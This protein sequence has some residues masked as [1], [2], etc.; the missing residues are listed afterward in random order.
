VPSV[1]RS[2]ALQSDMTMPRRHV[3][4]KRIHRC[5]LA[6]LVASFVIYSVMSY[7]GVRSPDS[8]V[9]FRTGKSLATRGT[10][11]V[12]EE[13]EGWPGFGL[14]RAT[15][16]NRYSVFGPGES[17][18]IVPLI[19]FAQILNDA[20]WYEGVKGFIQ[21]SHYV[22]NGLHLY[23]EG[24]SPHELE[25][26]A[27]RFV[28]SFFNVLVS[29][30]AVVCFLLVLHELVRC[31]ATACLVTVL[32]AFGTP[33]FP[34]SG[35]F[36]SEPLA[37]LLC[38]VSL[39]CM[40]SSS[41][42]SRS[43]ATDPIRLAMA[44][45][46]LGA[47]ILTH[48]TAVLFVPF[49]LFYAMYKAFLGNR[50]LSH[51]CMAGLCFGG[52]VAAALAFL[53]YYNYV[54]FGHALETGR[55]VD[56]Q[57]EYGHFAIPWNGLYGLLFSPGKGLFLYAPAT[58]PALFLWP[59]FYRRRRFL[60]VTLLG[61]AL[62]RLVFIATRSDW[63]GGFCL[64]PRYMLM[65]VPFLLIPWGYF[66]RDLIA[67]NRTAY[68]WL[69]GVFVFACVSEQLYFCLGEIF[70]FLHVIKWKGWATGANVFANE[71]LYL[72]WSFSPLNG[73]LDG[74]R[75]PFL[76]Q[77]L[78]LSNYALWRVCMAI[79]GSAL[80]LTTAYLRRA[81]DRARPLQPGQVSA[82]SGGADLEWVLPVVEE[83]E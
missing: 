32:F 83:G 29:S 47:A 63:S 44:G 70:S 67:K 3:S 60:A 61:A 72:K 38:L 59:W 4:R 25:P 33:L 53:G 40:V 54:R 78:A 20:Q 18:A 45:L 62:F 30:L 11:A 5:A 65:L 19:W 56:P 37:T 74:K 73:L 71:A 46:S 51:L 24:K 81:L 12:A 75:G 41:G 26:H 69:F 68:L 31:R 16:G 39:Y 13:L 14:P 64:G 77:R 42:H 82:W 76:L 22:G 17:V 55:T 48:I 27:L 8:E 34:Y 2:L 50:R 15:D 52:G 10:F 7:G 28:V 66:L 49:F 6:L 79:A 35:T 23:I 80:L 58:L 43:H 9:V 57:L 36:F 21:S 1:G